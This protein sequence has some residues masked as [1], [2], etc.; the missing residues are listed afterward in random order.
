M[1]KKGAERVEK[2]HKDDV[3]E[4]ILT[5]MNNSLSEIER[6]FINEFKE[7]QKPL[8]FI[9]GSQ[10]SGT[11][12]LMQLLIQR[13]KLS[14]PS[15]FIARF[16]SCPYIGAKLYDSFRTKDTK[17]EYRSDLGFTEGLD[18][19]H[20]FGYFWKKWFPWLAYE[21]AEYE[22]INYTEL[23]KELA[24]WQ[25][26]RNEPIIFKNLIYL[27]YH[28]QKIYQE[29]NN[30]YFLNIERDDIYTIQSSYLSRLKLFGKK[31]SWF[32]IKPRNFEDIRE[33]PP[34]EQVT[35]QVLNIKKDIRNQLNLI[36]ENRH[37]TIR[38]SDLVE[39]PNSV[40]L[41]VE[42]LIGHKLEFKTNNDIPD[43]LTNANEEKVDSQ[44]FNDM[45]RLLNEYQNKL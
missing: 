42:N 17:S 11:T 4:S 20:E 5:K 12:L 21:I 41:R 6:G 30:S 15:N 43:Q 44:L 10:R 2:Y 24:A 8:I 25:S 9:V 1:E 37:I 19:P 39:D 34:L 7:P 16:W 33:L 36:P 45:K 28:I 18:G 3:L 31:I 35:A 38:Y 26:V 29:F 14:Y 13:Y 22:L 23:R 32:G 40:L 27:T